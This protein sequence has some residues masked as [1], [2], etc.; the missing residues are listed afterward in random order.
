MFNDNKLYL[1][2]LLCDVL[3]ITVHGDIYDSDLR[4][5]LKFCIRP[6]IILRIT[7]GLIFTL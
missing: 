4:I 7:F 1:H 3:W 6:Y 5:L 2:M